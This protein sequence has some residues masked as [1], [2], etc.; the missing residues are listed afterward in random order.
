MTEIG[1]LARDLDRCN[2]K[3]ISRAFELLSK[4]ISNTVKHHY[5]A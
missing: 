2:L 5:T 3:Y 1:S 4:K